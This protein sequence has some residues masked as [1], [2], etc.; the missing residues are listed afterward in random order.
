MI[1]TMS[2]TTPIVAHQSVAATVR[3]EEA[4]PTN[5][6]SDATVRM[7]WRGLRPGGRHG[8]KT[9]TEVRSLGRVRRQ[10]TAERGKGNPPPPPDKNV[11]KSG[12]TARWRGRGGCL[13]P[14]GTDSGRAVA[15][16]ICC[17]RRNTFPS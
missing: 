2:A 7:G 17:G 13:A 3:G 15:V 14:Y 1:N 6:S 16:V 4:E 12:P 5:R 10:R 8:Q 11:R 9:R